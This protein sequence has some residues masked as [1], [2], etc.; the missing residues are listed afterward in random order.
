MTTDR[1]SLD[2]VNL[3]RA[4]K[5]AEQLARRLYVGLMS[6]LRGREDAKVND[7][8]VPAD[9]CAP[10]PRVAAE[11]DTLISGGIVPRTTS[12]G[13]VLR[14][15]RPPQIV[16]AVVGDISIA[17]IDRWFAPPAGHVEP[18]QFMFAVYAP[19]DLEV[20]TILLSG[21]MTG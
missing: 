9:G 19:I 11:G 7:F 21:D 15:G 12:V 4:G 8:S 6:L 17:V 16:P 10:L 1:P 5:F 3:L 14:R 13:V 2:A 18:R 20:P